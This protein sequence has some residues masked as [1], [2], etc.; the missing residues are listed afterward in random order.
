[1]H[2]SHEIFRDAELWLAAVVSCA[3]ALLIAILMILSLVQ[4]QTPG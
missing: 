1:M 4:S 2:D 3:P